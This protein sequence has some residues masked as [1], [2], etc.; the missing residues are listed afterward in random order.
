M[1]V[2]V[3]VCVCVCEKPP[4]CVD[5]WNSIRTEIINQAQVLQH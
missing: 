1:C 5:V 2:C 3:C 4:G